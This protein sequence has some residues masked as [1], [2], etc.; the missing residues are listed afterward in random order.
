MSDKKY[1]L[2]FDVGGTKI[3]ACLGTDKGE[4]I[5][6]KRFDSMHS[7][8]D[9]VLPAMVNEGMQLLTDAGIT[10]D[11]LRAIGIGAPAPM[12]IPAG[13]ISPTNMKNWVNVPV[14]SYIADHFNVETYFDND[15]NAGAL[16]EWIFGS[17]QGVDNM[18]Y[19]TLST[20][21][22]GGVI[23]NGHL[24]HG[25]AFTAGECGH[26]TLD[27]NG[28]E[29]N[30]G[31]HGCYEA[32]C[33]GRAL[34]QRMQR[35]LADKPD[36]KIVQYAGGN[37]KNV[38]LIALE[39]A[40]KDGDEYAVVLWDEMCLRHAQAIGIFLNIFNPAKI[41]LGTIAWAAGDLFMKPVKKYLPDFCW[42]ETLDSCDLTVSALGREIGEYSGI[43][44]ALNCLYEQGR[45]QLPW[46]K[47]SSES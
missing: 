31:M 10:A 12:D 13:T 18:L 14:K 1:I 43:A 8:P 44:V 32:F 42:K 24:V 4:I 23:T 37:I 15:A 9:E 36:N 39:K 27:L 7:G 3:A 33:G 28:P 19:L 46:K 22:G 16:A 47:R 41:V 25:N 2:G 34:A 40:V 30:C 6:S 17:G 20:G 35:E 5:G 45:W 11:D 29:C 38:D 21:I 26:I